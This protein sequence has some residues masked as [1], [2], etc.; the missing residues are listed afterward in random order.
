MPT[1]TGAVVVTVVGASGCHLCQDADAV[2]AGLGAV[3]DVEH[4]D[5]ASERGRAL[6][7]AHRAALLPLV[8]VDDAWFSAGRLP[9]RKLE[10][11]LDQRRAQVP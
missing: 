1:K 9:R 7:A 4:V 10:R 2:L 8:L 5:A 6:L 3:V 11:L